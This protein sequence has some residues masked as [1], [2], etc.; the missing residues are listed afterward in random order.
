[1][2]NLK[3]HGRRILSL[4]LA[5]LI[6][7]ILV[8]WSWNLSLPDIFGLPSIQ[9][10][11]AMGLIL[12]TG[13]LSFIFHLGSWQSSG[14]YP[15]LHHHESVEALP[16]FS[17]SFDKICS[18]NVV[19]FWP[20]PVKAYKKLHSL[21]APGVVIATTYMPRHSGATSADTRRKEIEII[22]QLSLA[23]F[24]SIRTEEKYMLPVSVVS[25]LAT[26]DVA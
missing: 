2:K 20:D 26:K 18:A 1:M 7:M 13:I 11:H 12:L 15:T 9:A 23:G 22:D 16:D 8:T 25:V 21:L 3:H 4:I 19:Q 24:S 6:L 17:H 5:L 10:K 14:R